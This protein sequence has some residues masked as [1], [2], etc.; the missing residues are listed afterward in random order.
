MRLT[1]GE[2]ISRSRPVCLN[3]KTLPFLLLFFFQPH[4]ELMEHAHRRGSTFSRQLEDFCFYLNELPQL[5][6][7]IKA[8]SLTALG[9]YC[10]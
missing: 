10:S 3:R 5:D 6:F 4:T 1:R 9:K 2:G 7:E 8:S